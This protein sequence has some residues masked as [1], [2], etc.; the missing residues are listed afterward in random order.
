MKS[1]RLAIRKPNEEKTEK[2]KK[3]KKNVL[4]TVRLDASMPKDGAGCAVCGIAGVRRLDG[5]PVSREVLADMAARLVHRG[6][7]DTGI[8][9]HGGVGFAHTRL[10]IIDVVGSRQPMAGAGGH[11]H[12]VFNGEILNY[13][14]LR[15]G[16]S[17]PFRTRGDT[18]VLL[19]LYEK[20]GPA[21]VERLHGQF[22]YA[23]HDS[24]T[25]DTHLFRDRLGILPLYYYVNDSVFAFASEIKAL[26]PVI[27]SP[28]VDEDSLHDYLAH[29]SVPAPYT[30]IKGVRKVPQGHHLVV[31]S[32]GTVH[33]TAYWRLSAQPTAAR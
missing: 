27:G 19:A 25:G 11:T 18:E 20:Y 2:E 26:L 17:Y 1:R 10:S 22:A 31:K 8:W 30:L 14:E 28:G 5:E 21:G 9:T 24:A 16:L 32:D 7:D 15:A 12:L 4:L 29:R 13:R 3:K 33:S 6:P 23:I